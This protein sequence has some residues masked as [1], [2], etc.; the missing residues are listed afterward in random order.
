MQMSGSTLD[1]LDLKLKD[2]GLAVCRLMSPLVG[3]DAH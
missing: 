3:S 2:W 1:V